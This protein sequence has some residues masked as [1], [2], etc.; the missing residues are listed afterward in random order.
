MSTLKVGIVGLPNVGKSTL[1][2]AITNSHAE[3]ANYPFVTISPN[4]GIAVVHDE[5]LIHLTKIFKPKKGPIFTTFQFYDIAGLVKNAH[6]GE[7]LGNQFLSH[8]RDCNVIIEIIRCFE[9]QNIIHVENNIDPK[10]DIEIIELELILSDYEIVNKRL[11]KINRDNQNEKILFEKNTL[12]KIIKPLSEG[13]SIRNVELSQTEYNYLFNELR[14]IS[15]KP[16]L[17]V[18]NIN[19]ENLDKINNNKY[20]KVIKDIAKNENIDVIPISCELELQLST[21][22]QDEKITFLNSINRKESGLDEL[23]KKCYDLLNLATFFTVGKDECR[24]WSFKKNTTAYNCA[25]IIHSDFKKGFIKAEVYNYNDFKEF[26]N[27]QKVR[28]HGKIRTE[29]RDYL[30]KDGDIIVF[31][32]NV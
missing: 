4:T 6:K 32:F 29:G 30:V 14:L 20:F 12:K 3:V 21:L 28:E 19:E 23:I 7:G 31:K 11:S 2:N 1:F 17:Y 13:K 27:E 9:D 22:N 24:A 25:E 8:I 15:I 26:E 16:I 10:R 18:A 5:R